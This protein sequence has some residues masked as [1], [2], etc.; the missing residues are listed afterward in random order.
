MFMYMYV[1]IALADKKK[2]EEKLIDICTCHETKYKFDLM[3][4]VL[5]YDCK[6]YEVGFC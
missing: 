6:I 1:L 3:L 5:I 2:K 4:T